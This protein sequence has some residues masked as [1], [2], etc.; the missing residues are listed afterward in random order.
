M[1]GH[2]LPVQLTTFVGRETEL[3]EISE[4]LTSPECRLLTL[5]GPGGIGKTRLALAAAEAQRGSFADGIYFVP[6]Q[7]LSSATE[8]A[9]SIASAAGLRLPQRQGGVKEQLLNFLREK[10]ILLLL[11]NFDHLLEGAYLVSD[12]LTAAPGVSVL[13]TS[14][15]SLKLAAE[16]R[17]EVRGMRVPEAAN[18]EFEQY[19]AVQLFAVR[20]RQVRH[21]FAAEKHREAVIQLC[22]LVG[23]MPL[24]IELA[25]SWLDALSPD[26]I[27]EETTRSLDI[28]NVDTFDVPERHRSIR[29]VLEPSWARLTGLERNV[30]MALSTF[31]GGFTRE[32]AESVAGATLQMLATL[33]ERSLLQRT[34]EP[35]Y[36]L[37]ELLR[38]FAAER[39]ALA[40]ESDNIQQRH[41]EYYAGMVERIAP[42]TWEPEEYRPEAL[43]QLDDEY[44]NLRAAIRWSL[45]HDDGV[46]AMRIVGAGYLFLADRAHLVDG[47]QWA[48]RVIALRRGTAA[49]VFV[50]VLVAASELAV[51]QGLYVQAQAY[52]IEALELARS[53]GDRALTGWA[54]FLQAGIALYRLDD[55]DLAQALYE[56]AR[57]LFQEAGYSNTVGA[58]LNGLGDIAYAR[59]DYERAARY[60]EEGLAKGMESGAKSAMRA[61]NLGN[62][63]LKMGQTARARA[64]F[65]QSLAGALH[66]GN[67]LWIAQIIMSVANLAA[68]QGYPTTAASLLGACQAALATIGYVVDS[69][70]GDD[71]HEIVAVTRSQLDE[72]GFDTSWAAG[73][74]MTLDEAVIAAQEALERIETDIWATSSALSEP[75]T[76]RELDVL[77]LVCE[78]RHNRDIAEALTVTQ[79]TVK[80]H[81]K[82]IFQKLGVN[83]RVQAVTRAKALELL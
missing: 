70:E 9:W 73:H 10:Q 61:A 78:G 30:Y 75:L 27:V 50:K 13:A 60:F 29:L 37:H 59:G 57:L 62:A 22:R 40:G 53:L 83:S 5:V 35:R 14:Q 19:D 77:R 8:V 72:A 18:A 1:S 68:R 34:V 41:A 51:N 47:L 32:A 23:G 46:L 15:E 2:N 12:I 33:V 7:P 52:S 44:D 55:Y 65:A 4:Q 71:L 76:A 64:L 42:Q 45:T 36:H 28:L 81:L 24:G 16:W 38:H 11:D 56:E 66:L 82:H 17:Y 31:Q 26:E 3:L 79:N 54:L 6:L 20:A 43:D 39:L 21:D 49:E 80:T 74:T 48:E 69:I 67:P 58:V 63:L 25:A